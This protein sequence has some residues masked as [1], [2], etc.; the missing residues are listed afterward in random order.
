MIN[1]TN[2]ENITQQQRKDRQIHPSS[3]KHN[4]TFK[5]QRQTKQ[6]KAWRKRNSVISSQ[7]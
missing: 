4:I 7:L 3:Q 1:S 5:I 6:V 2:Q